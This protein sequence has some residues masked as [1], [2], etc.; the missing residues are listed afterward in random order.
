MCSYTNL[1]VRCLTSL[2]AAR[3][4]DGNAFCILRQSGPNLCQ[5]PLN[6]RGEEGFEKAVAFGVRD[7]T[8]ALYLVSEP[9]Y[10]RGTAGEESEDED[11]GEES[12]Y[13]EEEEQVGNPL[14]VGEARSRSLSYMA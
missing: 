7:K 10:G 14:T 13:E 5:V 6:E 1:L 9:G 4:E 12:E 3:G 2:S 8:P 11:D